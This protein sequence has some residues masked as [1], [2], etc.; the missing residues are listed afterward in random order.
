MPIDYSNRYQDA[1]RLLKKYWGYDSF[2]QGQD[3]V[4]KSVLNGSDTLVLFPTGGGKSL[5]YQVPALVMDGLTLVISPLVAL[6][7]DQ[8][9]QLR[10]YGI[11]AEFINSTI[12]RYEVEQRVINARNGMYRLLYVAPERLHTPLFQHELP[13]M[14]IEL[15][16]VD[17]AH[18]ISEWGHEFRPS[19]RQ[20][21]EWIEATGI[22]PRWMALTATA[23]PKVRDDIISSLNFKNPVIVTKT[24]ER[25][26]L[27]W[28]VIPTHQKRSKLKQLLA[29]AEGSGLIYAGTRREC[30]Q[31]AESISTSGLKAAAYH[32]GLPAE[33]RKK[34]QTEWINDD[35]PLV[36]A[37]NAF[38]MGIDKP[39]CRY[40]VHWSV[41]GSIEAYYQE[42]GR[43]GRDGKPSFPVLL[44]SQSDLDRLR[45]Q[46]DQSHPGLDVLHKVYSALCD[47]LDLALGTM[48]E[49]ARV[50]DPE[51]ISKRSGV[52]LKV[53][54][55]VMRALDRYGVIAMTDDYPPAIGILFNTGLDQICNPTQGRNS[56]KDAFGDKMGRLYSSD[57]SVDM[58]FIDMEVVCDRLGMSR[59]A[60]LKGLEVFRLDGLLSY[61]MRDG[62]PLVELMEPRQG[63]VPVSRETVEQYRK[64]LMAK[65]DFMEG[66]A[67][68][69]QCRSAYL[70][71]YFG[72]VDVPETC[73]NCD[74]CLAKEDVDQRYD[75]RADAQTVLGILETGHLSI[76]KLQATLKWRR[77]RLSKSLKWLG[78]EGLI[79]HQ[80]DVLKIKG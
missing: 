8:V 56:A 37:T 55:H 66:Y 24:F 65:I 62:K 54:M 61:E 70:R 33:K 21:R 64:H 44:Y 7:E 22:Q 19:Y 13:D 50:V 77:D 27:K 25:S 80:G 57:A 32:A 23:T 63:N 79:V 46:I 12:S 26:N 72:E 68:T 4:V 43:A 59:N 41:P 60:I 73:G 58:H 48:H 34:I 42:A 51:S 78:S 36:V 39:D 17:E 9:S 29:R 31:L 76:P 10:R 49:T 47:S 2:R 69:N 45:K 28:W 14:N 53:M 20:I 11:S 16:A 15:V 1:E 30:E 71:R 75:L 6:M 35:T 18:C 52:P 40:V 3:T 38:G 5:C 74:V 67:L